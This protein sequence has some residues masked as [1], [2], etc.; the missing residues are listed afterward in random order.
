MSR[1]SRQSLGTVLIRLGVLSLCAALSGECLPAIAQNSSGSLSAIETLIRSKQYDQAVQTAQRQLRQAPTNYRLWTLKAIALSLK[2]ST[3]DAVAAFE[4]ALHLSPNYMPA[5]KG[6]VQLLYGN[7]DERAAPLLERILK[8]DPGDSTAHEML[9]ILKRKQ[10]DCNGAVEHF[11]PITE[12]LEKH[13]GSLEAYGDCLVQLKRYT[14][15]VPV[16]QKL[17]T[18][19][20]DQSY[21][22]YDLAVVLISAKQYDLALD[23]LAPL[24]AANTQDPDVLSLASEVNE[25]L[26][27]TPKAVALLR[28]AI[29]LSPS[30]ADYYAAFAALCFDHDSFQTGIRMMDVGLKHLPDNPAIYLSR[31]LL[32]AQLAEYDAAEADFRKA[33]QLDST[34]SVSAYALDLAELQ[35]NNPQRALEKVQAQVK[36]HPES[37]LLNFLLAKLLTDETPSADSAAF[38]QALDSVQR[39][40]HLEPNLVS[41]HD[42]LAKMYLDTGQYDRAVE[43]CHVAL[44]YAPADETATYHLV[45]ALRH[46]GQKDELPALVKRLSQLHQDSLKKETERK[47]FQL[48]VRQVPPGR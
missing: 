43:E 40:V 46:M 21:P 25:A 11:A 33:E 9:A 31:G 4:K 13:A 30:A 23:A 26:G 5:L 47:R 18:A 36:E 17:V 15:A 7:A 3:S 16:F 22:R 37:A 38:K 24:L 29:V 10:G 27:N 12:K 41:A 48:E 42:L 45:I 8:T 2:G 1:T 6:E 32:H 14:D 35:K 19:L 20:P 34:Q 28:Q 44:Q 39:A